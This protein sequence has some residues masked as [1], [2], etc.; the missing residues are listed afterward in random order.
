MRSEG[1]AESDMK[2][3]ESRGC[4]MIEAPTGHCEDFVCI[5]NRLHGTRMRA[6]ETRQEAA[7][8]IHPKALINTFSTVALP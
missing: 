5:E 8:G 6:R 7:P 2:P 3:E 1:R 4:W